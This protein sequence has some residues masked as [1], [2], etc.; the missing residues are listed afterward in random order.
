MKKSNFILLFIMILS[1]KSYCQW[2]DTLSGMINSS[3]LVMR[4]G[5]FVNSSFIDG[6]VNVSDFSGN[7]TLGHSL[8]LGFPN[9][10]NTSLTLIYNANANHTM[11]EDLVG[12]GT[13][14]LEYAIHDH[15]GVRS[16]SVNSAAWIFGVNGIAIQSTNFEKNLYLDSTWD[17]TCP[18]INPNRGT[19]VPILLTG[20]N[21]T[22]SLEWPI[23]RNEGASWPPPVYNYR[24]PDPLPAGIYWYDRIYLSN[25]EGS[26]I[27]LTNP[28]KLHQSFVSQVGEGYNL[29]GTYFDTN[30]ES[31]GY[32]V[33]DW[34]GAI[35][36]LRKID[37]KPGDGLTYHFEE[38]YV[39]YEGYNQEIQWYLN[40]TLAPKIAYLKEIISSNG[41]KI[42]FGYD[43]NA[44][45]YNNTNG[46]KFCKNI[47][48]YNAQGV[49]STEAKL[50]FNYVKTG[51]LF[52]IDVTNVLGNENYSI[53]LNNYN[54]NNFD[55]YAKSAI[56]SISNIMMV[57]KIT[58]NLNNNKFVTFNYNN[59]YRKY[60]YARLIPSDEG[61]GLYFY[62]AKYPIRLL[63]SRNVNLGEHN[64]FT[65]WTVTELDGT[66]PFG[67]S[68]N[69]EMADR[70]ETCESLTNSGYYINTYSLNPTENQRLSFTVHDNTQENYIRPYFRNYN[71][72]NMN[73]A[74]RDNYATTMIKSIK[75]S[76][77]SSIGVSKDIS[78]QEY[79]YTWAKTLQTASFESGQLVFQN[80]TEQEYNQYSP[81]VYN[82]ITEIKDTNLTGET[83]S[84][85]NKYIRKKYYS[86]IKSLS[87]K[88]IQGPNSV[89]HPNFGSE[90]RIDKEEVKD[91]NGNLINAVV[92]EYNSGTPE[93][94]IPGLPLVTS[95]YYIKNNLSS[96]KKSKQQEYFGTLKSE[97]AYD[98]HYDKY[99]YF[100]APTPDPGFNYLADTVKIY[101]P[102]VN[103]S[104]ISGVYA[105]ANEIKSIKDS[106]KYLNDFASKTITDFSNTAFLF[107]PSLL[108]EQLQY[109][110]IGTSSWI[111]NSRNVNTYYPITE[112]LY[113]RS[114]PKETYH[115]GSTDDKYAKETYDYYSSGNTYG[116]LKEKL[117][118]N[119][120]KETY[121]YNLQNSNAVGSIVYS[122]GTITSNHSTSWTSFQ[123]NPFKVTK[124]Y[125]SP[126]GTQINQVSY[127]GIDGKG[128]T[129]FTVD[130][131]G[132]YSSYKYDN[133]GRLTNVYNPKG[134]FPPETVLNQ[135][136]NGSEWNAFNDNL[137]IPEITKTVPFNG[138]GVQPYLVSKNKFSPSDI[139][140][141][142][143]VVDGVTDILK[144]KEKLNYL[145]KKIYTEDGEGRKVY[146]LYDDY[147]GLKETRFVNNTQ[148]S[149]NQK[150]ILEYNDSPTYFKRIKLVDE[151]GKY[152]WN[153]YDLFGNVIKNEKYKDVSTMLTTLFEYDEL[154]RLKKVTSPMGKIS[155]YE[156]D[157]WGNINKRKTPDTNNPTDNTKYEKYKYSKY[158]KLR[159]S[160]NTE[161]SSSERSIIFTK[162]DQLNRPI[163]TGT[164]I[165]TYGF[166]AMNP[167]LDYSSS[168]GGI[169]NF[170]N[171]NSDTSNF[172]VMN[173]YDS[174][175]KYS[176]FT[177]ITSDPDANMNS[178]NLKGRLVATAFRDKVNQQWNYKVYGYDYFGRVNFYA[179]KIG[180]TNWKKI[181]T[182]YDGLGNKTYENIDNQ[183][184]FWY[185][186]D[187]QGRL[188]KVSSNN[189]TVGVPNTEAQYSYNN[190]NQIT[191][192]SYPT[193]SNT[194]K[195]NTSFTYDN[196]RGWAKTI[197][198]ASNFFYELS[199]YVNNGNIISK[200]ITNLSS[201]LWPTLTY[202]YL[203]DD[204]NRLT[205]ASNPTYSQSFTYDNDGNF[206]TKVTNG[207]TWN[208]QYFSGTNKLSSFQNSPNN[209]LFT[210]DYKGNLLTNSGKSLTINQ[211]NY[212]HRNLPLQISK[213]SEVYK[214]IYDDGGNR[215]KKTTTYFNEI[216]LRDH[217]GLERA[218]YDVTTGKIKFINVYG[219]G[220]I[221]RVE[222]V[223]S[224]QQSAE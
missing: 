208:Y 9:D 133:L 14:L 108:S 73:Y 39:K 203:Y 178:K 195:R 221:G 113:R 1:M 10:L 26:T 79:K 33:V 87:S 144:S 18:C 81:L 48:Y 191:L 63:T 192:Q 135:L 182:N 54:P 209:Y 180:A 106:T 46:R 122:N 217:T 146:Y 67:S 143:Y 134:Y 52:K 219:N 94:Y 114:K 188:S 77:Y 152:Q 100:Y 119:G 223:N 76:I 210:Y 137:W 172:V 153:Y 47:T 78:L 112:P 127:S 124:T 166:D 105:V 148:S 147:L 139:S 170:E 11:F 32:A 186:Y 40:G 111:R 163:V 132:Y 200:T 49:A 120:Y 177:N 215:I 220:L 189:T 89:E 43:S 117:L 150:Q 151:E 107:K 199:N 109:G 173:M 174:Y 156:Y 115:Y 53:E 38:E 149:P 202:V 142:S 35:Y 161:A 216:Y 65:Y 162:Y 181:Y 184:Y 213:G 55:S 25:A 167:D 62:F 140:Y 88:F 84:L 116:Y 214:Y 136:T 104:V 207:A 69:E 211:N 72:K 74:A 224:G 95:Y 29:V 185:E 20:Y 97:T 37:Y 155:T 56:D 68:L 45:G 75:N 93:Y 42:V 206:L 218:I 61:G 145:G 4:G 128:N 57:K 70:I 121:E 141:L 58:N 205:T 196:N 15:R 123:A 44:F 138:E 41:D 159:F 96:L 187:A 27:T 98:Y 92:Y 19:Q 129:I 36:G 99:S 85:N 102:N 31:N 125:T 34:I 175:T 50:T 165:S 222:F 64:E 164:L 110:K 13:P 179:V 157:S 118:D 169:T 190:A 154:N 24:Y 212:D 8:S 28:R 59:H 17:G 90:I 183:Y 201:S 7:I 5:T 3:D 2:S 51:N 23:A 103:T 204:L 176:V 130:E 193:I 158:G 82:I 6:K 12:N 168:Q 80:S 126:T 21:Y 198:Y 30:E 101:Y 194:S 22:N 197:N 91:E 160:T 83:T 71:I 16:N 60:N 86:M 131:N 171:L 66:S